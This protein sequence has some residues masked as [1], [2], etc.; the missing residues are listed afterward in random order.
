MVVSEG[1]TEISKIFLSPRDM[2]PLMSRLLSK[3]HQCVPVCSQARIN[4]LTFVL[5]LCNTTCVR[6][7]RRACEQTGRESRLRIRYPAQNN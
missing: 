3:W 4:H 1:E 5:A 2:L 7:Q 6:T